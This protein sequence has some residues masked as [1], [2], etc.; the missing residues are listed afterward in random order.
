MKYQSK[1]DETIF[2]K[3]VEYDDKYKTYMLEYTTGEKAGKTIT[4]SEP[5]L[6]RWWRKVEDEVD[7]TVEEVVQKDT[8]EQDELLNVK[9]VDEETGKSTEVVINPNE[10]VP[11][12]DDAPTTYDFNNQEKKH[13]PMPKSVSE[14]YKLGDD[15]Y[16]TVEEIVDMV[17]SWGVPVKAYREWIKLFDSTK[18]IFRRN[19]RNVSKS[20]IEVRMKNDVQ[21]DGF[22]TQHVPSKSALIKPTPYVIYVKTMKELEQVIKLLHATNK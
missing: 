6:K 20:L 18:I 17:V 2:A 14:I 4:V 3:L 19:M 11:G 10:F 7:G 13:I 22:E 21:I 8:T 16:P 12:V 1:K 15:P 9:V 5:T